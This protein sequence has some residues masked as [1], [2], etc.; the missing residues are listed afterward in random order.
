[1]PLRLAWAMTVHRAA[2]CL[3][4]RVVVDLAREFWDHGQLAVALSRVARAQDMRVH[5]ARHYGRGWGQA[6]A[7]NV[8]FSG[9]L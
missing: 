5:V 3:F 8:V 2:H 7:Q 4:D 6:V 1:M 9:L